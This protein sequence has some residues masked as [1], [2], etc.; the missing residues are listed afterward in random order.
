VIKTPGEI[1]RLGAVMF[2]GA[3][4]DDELMNAG[5][6]LAAAVRNGQRVRTLSATHGE[7]GARPG[8][9]KDIIGDIR[10]QEQAASMAVLGIKDQVWLNYHDG[11][12]ADT[13][14]MDALAQLGR[15]VN[16]FRPD[17]I[18]TFGPDGLTGHPD[19]RTIS[20]WVGELESKANVYWI[21][22]EPEQYEQ[23]RA[24]DEAI[25]I[26]FKIK[27]PPLVPS[28]KCAIDFKLTPELT[29]L[30]RKAFEAV[31]SQYERLF[32]TK[33]FARPGE[34][35]ARECFVKATK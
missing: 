29:D 31:P 35:L 32:E 7:A 18:L 33:P 8:W 6:I 2:V 12:L 24:A 9:P 26:F 17:T 25:N 19:H 21:V 13:D 5:G 3:H 15:A 34:A 11:F 22:V 28:E 20:R 27:Q 23:L 16:D 14:G 4:P 1:A 30:K 10:T